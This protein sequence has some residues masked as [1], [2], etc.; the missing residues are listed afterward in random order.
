[1][2]SFKSAKVTVTTGKYSGQLIIV[3]DIVPVNN[4]E[5]TLLSEVVHLIVNKGKYLL[6][7]F[8]TI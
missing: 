3:D 1:M 2:G 7:H 4:F 6:L 5:I 8:P